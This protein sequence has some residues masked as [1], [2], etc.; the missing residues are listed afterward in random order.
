MLLIFWPCRCDIARNFLDAL[1]ITNR[2]A[3]YGL[4]IKHKETVHKD[5][6]WN[7]AFT[8]RGGKLRIRGPKSCCN[9]I[10]LTN[11]WTK[12]QLGIPIHEKFS[13]ENRILF[14]SPQLFWKLALT[15]VE[16][17]VVVDPEDWLVVLE[18]GGELDKLVHGRGDLARHPRG[19]VVH[20][21]RRLV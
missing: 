2:T 20:W 9:K 18:R 14:A 4:S 5:F 16:V 12:R 10:I 6:F 3:T 15:F 13:L 7:T 19:V 11:I 17:P 8:L 1:L 21:N